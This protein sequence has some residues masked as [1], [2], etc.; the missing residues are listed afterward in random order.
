[1]RRRLYLWGDVG[2]EVGREAAFWVFG[3]WVT[4]SINQT[5]G[6]RKMMEAFFGAHRPYR[7]CSR[8]IRETIRMIYEYIFHSILRLKTTQSSSLRATF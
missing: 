5:G 7:K 2:W 1:M 6:K 3:E 4:G 8:N